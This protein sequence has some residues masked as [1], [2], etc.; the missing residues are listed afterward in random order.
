MILTV[1]PNPCID[2][3]VYVDKFQAGSLN[4]INKKVMS[5]SG[6]AL[7]VAIVLRRLECDS[8]ATGF[9]FEDGA[10]KYFER[11]NSEGVPFI[12]AMCEGE[13]RINT[14]VIS[15]DDMSLTE[16]NEKGNPVSYQKQFE[17]IESIRTLSANAEITVFSGSLPPD[18]ED[19][20]YYRAGKAV[21]KS[22]K[23]VIDAEGDIL[24][25]ALKLKPALIKPNLYELTKTTGIAI[26]DMT[27]V[28]KA[29]DVLCREGA[30]RVLVSM[31]GKGAVIYNGRKAFMASSPQVEVKSTVGAGDSMVGAA[32]M[33]LSMDY[34]DEAIL[35]SA[36]AGGTAAVLGEGTDLLNK[37]TYERIYPLIETTRI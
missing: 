12:F 36:V 9:M 1:C 33:A 18:V 3:T 10:K 4:R 37:E 6:K 31:G 25:H 23:I 30:K 34:C 14:K 28:L 2:K 17:L 19:N 13:V 16:V 26:K 29:S 11:L 15:L 22:S 32:C 8:Y 7:N 35:K 5:L 27:D 24:R 21:H 20:F